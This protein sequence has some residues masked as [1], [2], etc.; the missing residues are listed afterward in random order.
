MKSFALHRMR[1]LFLT[2]LGVI[3]V[4]VFPLASNSLTTEAYAAKE[5]PDFVLYPE[6]LESSYFSL[7]IEPGE[8]QSLTVLLG[9]AGS[10]SIEARTYAADAYTLIN[11]GFGNRTEADGQSGPTKWIDYESE[12]L[13]L[14]P[15]VLLDRTF[16]VSVPEGTEPGQYVSAIVVQT[17]EPIKISG[18]DMFQQMILKSIAVLVTVPGPVEAGFKIGDAAVNQTAGANVLHIA[19]INGGNV[20][21]KPAGTLTIR[22]DSGEAVVTAPISMGSVYAG[23]ETTLEVGLSDTLMPGSYQFDL[24]LKDETTDA[25]ARAKKIE[26][27][28]A[29]PGTGHIETPVTIDEITIEPSTNDATGELRFVG[30]TVQVE[31]RGEPISATRMTLHVTRDGETVEDFVLSSSLALPNG[32]T[33][34]EQRYLP[35]DSWTPGSYE[36]SVTLEEI[37]SGGQA[38]RLAE[39]TAATTVE[40][41]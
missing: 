1:A 13:Q 33:T 15:A 4:A 30:L 29:D 11:G 34:V 41:P 32:L 20:L 18:S 12:T 39:S 40:V 23:M 19:I 38:T 14:D 22:D 21:V 17:A 24:S 37:G 2:T 8:S 36:F 3:V 26:I 35:S 5:L 7:T 31:N 27:Q 16:S 6:G 25:K 10:A 28:L 9:N